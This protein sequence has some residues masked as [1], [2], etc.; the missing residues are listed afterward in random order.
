LGKEQERE[1]QKRGY[2]PHIARNVDE[3]LEGPVMASYLPPSGSCSC[4][5]G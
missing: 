5:T 1:R 3:A 4:F 2:P